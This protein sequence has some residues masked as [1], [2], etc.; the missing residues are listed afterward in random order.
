ML[1][2]SSHGLYF[3][4]CLVLQRTRLSAFIEHL[5]QGNCAGIIEPP[6]MLVE[7][8]H[9]ELLAGLDAGINSISFVLAN[10]VGDSRGYNHKFV[11]GDSSPSGSQRT[12]GLAE[13][14]DQVAAELDANLL[15]LAHGKYIDEPCD[16]SGGTCGMDR[17][18]D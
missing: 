6:E 13:H 12:K 1:L 7:E 3:G 15:L 10:K 14:G 11:S 17:T 4:R 2:L 18:E 16:G 9:S 8:L 5:F